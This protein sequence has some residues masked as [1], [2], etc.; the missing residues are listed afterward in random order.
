MELQKKKNQKFNYGLGILKVILAFYV[1]CG[2]NFNPKSTKS[3]TLLYIL[4]KR[5]IH[6]PSFFIMSFYFLYRELI[7]PNINFYIKRIER[8]LIPYFF[9][10]IIVFILNNLLLVKLFNLKKYSFNDLKNQLIWGD[11]FIGQFWFQWVL[12]FLTSIFYSIRYISEKNFLF[13]IQILSYFSYILQYSGI[14]KKFNDF[15]DKNK[16]LTVGRINEMIPFA[17]TGSALACLG[18]IKKIKLFKLK[19]L[20]FCIL[21]FGSLEKYHVFSKLQGGVAYPGILLNVR[22]ICLIF[23]FSLFPS[24]NITNINLEKILRKITNYTTGI[25]YLHITIINYFKLFIKP[26]K[27]GNL[28][29]CIVIYLICYLISFFGTSIVGKSKLKFLF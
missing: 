15:L 6:V 17:V 19:T 9:W 1:I 28:Y 10:P 21:I 22:S 25:F 20:S 29:G 5:R 3:K 27:Y 12:I 18:I 26:I 14:N 4:R 16:K 7:I 23:F 11:I 13:L 2:H 24:E 8:L